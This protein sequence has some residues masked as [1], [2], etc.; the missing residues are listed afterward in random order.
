MKEKEKK[1]IKI[2]G[3]EV[4]DKCL[5]WKEKKILIIGDLHLGYEEVLKESGWA[6]PKTQMKETLLGLERIFKKTGRCKRII[7][8]GDVKHYFSGILGG[9]W[10]DF[11]ALMN[12]L[13][14]NLLKNGKITIIRGN[15]DAILEPMIYSSEKNRENFETEI[16]DWEFIE[17]VLFLHG[18]W[19]GMNKKRINKIE[20]E[21]KR[22]NKKIDLIVCGHFHPAFVLKDKSGVKM[23]KYKCFLYGKSKEIGKKLIIMPSFFP[24]IE[25]TDITLHDFKLEGWLDVSGFC[26]FALDDEGKVYDF[27]RVRGKNAQTRI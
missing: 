14:K 10:R 6:V 2:N 15:H 8:M 21:L 9:E 24:L 17:G 1:Q 26:V 22:E 7:L 19:K 11:Y 20:E 4:M 13:K 16:K 23:E 25:G 27:G 12:I 5:F 18:N 3:F